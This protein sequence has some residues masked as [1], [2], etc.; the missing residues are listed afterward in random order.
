MIEKPLQGKVGIV[1]G[2]GSGIG[3]AVARSFADAGATVV[4]ADLDEE[5]GA[6]SRPTSAATRTPKLQTRVTPTR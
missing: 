2:G 4:V 3:E 6:R 1:T 5:R